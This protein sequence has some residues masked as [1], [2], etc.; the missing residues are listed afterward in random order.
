MERLLRR[1]SLHARRE[2]VTEYPVV[3]GFKSRYALHR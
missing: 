2:V 1:C 3:S